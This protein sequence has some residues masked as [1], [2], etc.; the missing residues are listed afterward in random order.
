VLRSG[1]RARRLLRRHAAKRARCAYRR[2]RED[3]CAR[4]R[5]SGRNSRGCRRCWRGRRARR[6]RR[7]DRDDGRAMWRRRDSG[8]E[9]VDVEAGRPVNDDERDPAP[10]EDDQHRHEDEELLLARGPSGPNDDRG[11]ARAAWPIRHAHCRND[12]RAL[13]SGDRLERRRRELMHLVQRHRRRRVMRMRHHGHRMTRCHHRPG[14]HGVAGMVNARHG[15]SHR[16]RHLRRSARRRVVLLNDD[17]R[18]VEV[19]RLR[20]VRDAVRARRC[21]GRVRATLRIRHQRRGLRMRRR[22]HAKR[23]VQRIE[24]DDRRRS[25]SLLV[26]LTH[27]IQSYPIFVSLAKTHDVTRTSP[28]ESN[29]TMRA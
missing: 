9:V 3:A 20:R 25:E 5:Q 28:Q 8:Q 22:Q 21:V 17:A 18:R 15:R 16:R 13:S 29:R 7:G 26:V 11:Y 4:G 24:V 2:Q 19:D 1:G 6:C 14:A 10:D 27:A 23:C 12:V